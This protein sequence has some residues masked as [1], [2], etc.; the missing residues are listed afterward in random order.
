[1][2]TPV[3]ELQVVIRI[4]NWDDLLAAY[5]IWAGGH[6]RD[7]VLRHMAI[8]GLR[9]QMAPGGAEHIHINV[10][11]ADALC[12]DLE[13]P[14]SLGAATERLLS[15]VATL[16]VSFSGQAFHLLP[17]IARAG[18]RH[19]RADVIRPRSFSR[20]TAVDIS[21][22]GADI[23]LRT[24]EWKA[25]YRS[26]MRLAV[27]C[28]E[29]LRQNR[30]QFAWQPVRHAATGVD[31]LYHESLLRVIGHGGAIQPPGDYIPALE[32]LGLIRILDRHVVRRVIKELREAPS[33]SLAANISA[34]SVACDGWWHDL[35]ES[36]AAEPDVARRLVLEITE[37]AALP[38][39][40]VATAFV[41]KLRALG[42]RIAI[43][44]FG[45]GH[46]SLHHIVALKPDIVKIDAF[47]TCWAR[48]SADACAGLGHLVGLLKSLAPIVIVE[49]IGSE[50]ERI[51]ALA[52]GAA[53]QQGYHHG[54]PTSLRPSRCVAVS[55]ALARDRGADDLLVQ[56]HFAAVASAAPSIG[57]AQIL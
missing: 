18:Y 43:D 49:G 46:S 36:L 55:E 1:M 32:R 3:S 54:M 28:F 27:A 40:A 35:H 21:S 33:L 39:I 48:Q 7:A 29:A 25:T 22:S 23:A 24:E 53:W 2:R 10:H 6:I 38:S 34:H 42:C 50:E 13:G 45:M 56:A 19:E 37:S 9:C 12:P 41:G 8:P 26:D 57:I 4:D 15:R 11:N 31:I 20:E 47:Y 30:L 14:V 5:G 16:L 44:D 51:M 17:S 52:A